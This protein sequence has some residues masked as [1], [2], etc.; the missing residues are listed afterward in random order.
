MITSSRIEAGFGVMIGRARA[1][2]SEAMHDVLPIN[3]SLALNAGCQAGRHL[4]S[5]II[6]LW[7]LV[8]SVSART[9]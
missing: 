4:L 3:K 6:C 9:T 2:A 8:R 5:P 7:R 1:Y